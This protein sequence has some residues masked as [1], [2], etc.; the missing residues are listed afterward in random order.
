MNNTQKPLIAV[1]LKEE[2]NGILEKEQLDIIYTGLGKFNATYTI[3][4]IVSSKR[5]SKTLPPLII[6]F[7]TAG[8][9]KF[10]QGELVACHQFV[11]RDMDATELGFEFG[12]TPFDSTPKVITHPRIINSLPSALCGSGD[13]FETGN[14]KIEC[15]IVDMEAYALAK[16]CTKENIPFVS[17]KY[18]SDGADDNASKD[19]HDSLTAAAHKF[20]S[21]YK[22]FPFS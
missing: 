22:T 1:A 16:V 4:K 19:W 13:S 17:I 10:K 20:C 7:G 21:F 8:S 5:H 15:D 9:K 2:S 18:I 6:N 14:P 12:V 3:T 11:Q